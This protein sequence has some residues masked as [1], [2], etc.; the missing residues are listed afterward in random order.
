MPGNH[1]DFDQQVGGF[2]EVDPAQAS[3]ATLETIG[4]MLD[5][6]L[7][8]AHNHPVIEHFIVHAGNPIAFKKHLE[9]SYVSSTEVE[10]T[11]PLGE[12]TIYDKSC[13]RM[14]VNYSIYPD[15][16]VRRMPGFLNGHNWDTSTWQTQGEGEIVEVVV[17]PDQD[18]PRSLTEKETTELSLIMFDLLNTDESQRTG[19]GPSILRV[20][21]IAT[22]RG[23]MVTQREELH[24]IQG[25]I[26]DPRVQA[27]EPGRTVNDELIIK[28]FD[29]KD[30]Q[31]GA[32]TAVKY[33][34]TILEHVSPSVRDS[35]ELTIYENGTSEYRYG[36]VDF[37]P[38]PDVGE[39]LAHGGIS[40]A[41]QEFTM[42]DLQERINKTDEN[43][44]WENWMRAAGFHFASEEQ[45][46]RV[47]NT[48][49]DMMPRVKWWLTE[50]TNQ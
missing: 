46:Q 44:R 24:L 16:S 2:G 48:L 33:N 19:D 30:V 47:M 25:K 27:T 37:G 45:A 10:H 13:D 9:L 43:K 5:E 31:L 41:E 8:N 7:K 40:P 17:P 26:L 12:I 50:P 29:R 18:Y 28:A 32:Q 11:F 4:S 42:Q 36:Q 20:L 1:E 21:E 49:H 14:A 34:V 22:S 3:I 39:L 35:H 6:L 15:G 38:L 23:N